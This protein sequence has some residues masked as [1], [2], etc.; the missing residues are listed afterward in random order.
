MRQ[1]GWSFSNNPVLLAPVSAQAVIVEDGLDDFETESN[2]QWRQMMIQTLS[3]QGVNLPRVDQRKDWV[4]VR[5]LRSSQRSSVLTTLSEEGRCLLWP[6]DLCFASETGILARFSSSYQPLDQKAAKLGLDGHQEE[7]QFVEAAEKWIQ[8][9][10]DRD[11]QI[12]IRKQAQDVLMAQKYTMSSPMSARNVYGESH[13]MPGVY[14][15]PPDGLTQHQFPGI[16]QAMSVPAD[17]P[18]IYG[19]QDVEMKDYPATDGAFP[20]VTLPGQKSPELSTAFDDDLFGDMDGDAFAAKNAVTADDFDFF[21]QP[22]DDEID[23][24]PAADD[25]PENG[26][27]SELKS[28]ILAESPDD[29]R[30]KS[31]HPTPKDLVDSEAM[32]TS[33]DAQKQEDELGIMETPV[34]TPAEIRRRLFGL[35]GGL[36]GG[37]GAFEPVV[38]NEQMRQS[39]AKYSNAGLYGYSMPGS[40]KK[41]ATKFTL[42]LPPRKRVKV[43]EKSKKHAITPFLAMDQD[44]TD[45]SLNDDSSD[46]DEHDDMGY[47]AAGDSIIASPLAISSN[48]IALES[49]V[50][51]RR[52]FGLC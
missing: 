11:R 18:S 36:S 25:E 44:T 47:T 24:T 22:E 35:S 9:Q 51:N 31:S 48:G 10:P 45:S 52:M 5:L 26:V 50:S 42:S 39:D 33:P 7:A 19:T 17:T 2:R 46:T 37:R 8:E 28:G 30:L 3:F 12:A 6:L 23:V 34:L 21:D 20:A 38:F 27:D 16:D 40:D 49:I 13:G 29:L 15:T 43:A 1:T 4:K 41:R 32:M 14:P